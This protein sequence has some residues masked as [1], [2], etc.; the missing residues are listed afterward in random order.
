MR[1]PCLGP[2]IAQRVVGIDAVGMMILEPLFQEYMRLF[3]FTRL[4]LSLW[5]VFVRDV[6]RPLGEPLKFWLCTGACTSP[7]GGV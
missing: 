4:A 3:H 1:N 5:H 7:F 2:E 6:F